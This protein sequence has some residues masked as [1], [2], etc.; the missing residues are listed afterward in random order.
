M[1]KA[2]RRA[3]R[4]ARALGVDLPFDP[5]VKAK[6]RL[7]AKTKTKKGNYYNFTY[8]SNFQ[9]L[10]KLNRSA[11][12]THT[13]PWLFHSPPSSGSRPLYKITRW[14]TKGGRLVFRAWPRN[15]TNS[16]NILQIKSTAV[17]RPA[18]DSS[19]HTHQGMTSLNAPPF[20]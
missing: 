6:K 4:Y 17:W 18:L 7:A 3:V 8:P 13:R 14:T 9:T 19:C 10:S 16:R 11:G 5:L 20:L 15:P 2:Q 12:M 1:T